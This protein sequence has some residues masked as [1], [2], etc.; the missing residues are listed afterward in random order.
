MDNPGFKSG[1]ITSELR[2]F[3]QLFTEFPFLKNCET[4]GISFMSLLQSLNEIM[5]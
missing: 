3:G 1:L 2:D 5:M 4:N